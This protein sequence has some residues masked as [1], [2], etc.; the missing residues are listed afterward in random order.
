MVLAQKEE[1]CAVKVKMATEMYSKRSRY[2]LWDSQ[3][4]S[5]VKTDMGMCLNR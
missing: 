4:S 1:Y 5:T 2:F 3:S